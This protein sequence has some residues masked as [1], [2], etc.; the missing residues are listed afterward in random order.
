MVFAITLAA[1]V[2]LDYITMVSAAKLFLAVQGVAV[3]I[4]LAVVTS[5]VTRD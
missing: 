1:L 4:W 3:I 5:K 2:I